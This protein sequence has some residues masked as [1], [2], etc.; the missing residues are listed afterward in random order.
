MRQLKLFIE[1]PVKKL[2]RNLLAL[3]RKESRPDWFVDCPMLTEEAQKYYVWAF[4]KE[5]RAE[6]VGR[7]SSPPIIYF[8][9]IGIAF[10]RH[11]IFSCGWLETIDIRRA[12]IRMFLTL[13]LWTRLYV[14]RP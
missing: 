4:Q 6:N 1:K 7:M 9:T 10:T 13:A 5:P 14:G 12:S 3:E 2:Y 8:V 11:R